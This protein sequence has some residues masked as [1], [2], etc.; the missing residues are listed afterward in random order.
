MKKTIAGLLLF[1]SMASQAQNA[2]TP[3]L[4]SILL[5]QL[6]STHNQQEWFVPVNQS[7]AGITPEQAMWKDGNTNHS[8]G[9]LA[10][11]LLFWNKQELDKFN[12]EKP[13][14]FDGNNDETFNS[15]DKN[16]WTTVIQQLE[17]LLTAWEKAIEAA[18]EN[19]LKSWY[20]TIAHISTHN[21]YHTGQIMYIRKQQGSW[22][23]AKGVK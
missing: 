4:K 20:T 8:I 7:L 3:T 1:G 9:Q 18:D 22:D 14:A 2:G 12:G 19:K 10:N 15:F 21:A 6:K 5:D 16:S 17:N 13:S 11:H 23:P